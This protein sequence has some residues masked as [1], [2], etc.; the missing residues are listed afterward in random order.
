MRKKGEGMSSMADPKAPP[1]NRLWKRSKPRE[2]VVI[3]DRGRRRVLV[4]V[5]AMSLP[6]V[7]E[8][9]RL[10]KVKPAG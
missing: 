6:D 4:E 3:D 1:Q 10:A 9:Y 7:L 5:D 2:V 8:T